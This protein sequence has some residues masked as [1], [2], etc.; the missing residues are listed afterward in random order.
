V[1]E[2]IRLKRRELILGA[3][4]LLL[5][6]TGCS[7]LPSRGTPTPPALTVTAGNQI[8]PVKFGSYCWTQGRS[9]VCADGPG[10]REIFRGE[11]PP[12]VTGGASLQLKFA[13]Q[14]K[15]WTVNGFSGDGTQEVPVKA[16]PGNVIPLPAAS[17]T[18]I[19]SVTGNWP[20]HGDGNYL[21][22]FSVP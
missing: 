1:E 7:L 19:F 14:P 12:V 16:G 22:Q 18:Y 2:V 8:I 9:S 4:A 6:L 3:L 5:L 21:F 20:G 15:T 17:G 13:D 11:A 10:P